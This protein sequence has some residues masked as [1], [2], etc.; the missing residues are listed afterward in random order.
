[1]ATEDQLNNQRELNKALGEYQS[2][3]TDATEFIGLLTSRSS[4]L[5]D[6]YRNLGKST[7]SFTEGNQQTLAILKQVGKL[8]RDMQN[9]YEK[10]RDVQKD[11]EK[12]LRTQTNLQNS[13]IAAEQK[14]SKTQ[15]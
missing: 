10:I 11:I 12:G 13:L 9:P 8:A 6:Q 14:L 15:Y 2:G 1:M 7:K 5:V 3:L 4:D